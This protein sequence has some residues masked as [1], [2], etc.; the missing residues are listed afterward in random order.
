MV[1]LL[2]LLGCAYVFL[3]AVSLGSTP[4]AT[5]PLVIGPAAPPAEPPAAASDGAAW[6]QRMRPYCNPVEVAVRHRYDPPPTTAEGTGYSAACYALAG[7]IDSARAAILS[8]DQGARGR[9]AGILFDIGHPVADA[10]DDKSAGPMMSLVVEFWPDNYMALYHAGMSNYMIGE[11]AQA[12]RQLR[13][14]LALYTADDGW[15][16]NALEVLRRMDTGRDTP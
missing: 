8:L 3:C 14:F 2:T 9:A 16:S 1:R 15:R 13:R 11:R 4:R 5:E 10:G 7:R 6:F 12:A